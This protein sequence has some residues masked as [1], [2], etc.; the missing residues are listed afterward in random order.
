[1]SCSRTQYTDARVRAVT[2]VSR[3]RNSDHLT[4]MLGLFACSLP[5]FSCAHLVT[6]IPKF[7]YCFY[8]IAHFYSCGNA[9]PIFSLHLL[10]A[11][12]LENFVV[13]F[14][15]L[16]IYYDSTYNIFHTELNYYNT[17][18]TFMYE[19]CKE[20]IMLVFFT[21]FFILY[22]AGINIIYDD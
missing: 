17:V 8:F 14:S 7:S 6:L 2:S 10:L 20:Y 21:N 3:N 15:L 12:S 9:S 4:N 16:H 11:K 19:T 5:S 1:M 13:F 18:S 22:L